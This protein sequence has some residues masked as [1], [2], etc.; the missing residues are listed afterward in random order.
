MDSHA[1]QHWLLKF[2]K[3]SLKLHLALAK[4]AEW[5]SNDFLSWVA[6]RALLAGRLSALDKCP[7]IRPVG[8]GETW[9]CALTKVLVL[10]AGSEAI[11][12]CGIDQLCNMRIF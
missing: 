2:G 7:G 1:F 10:L 5:L 9:R 11:E 8:I 12:T 4:L 6:Y 3:A